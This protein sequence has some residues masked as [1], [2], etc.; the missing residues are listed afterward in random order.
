MRIAS[1]APSGTLILQELGAANNLVACTSLCPLPP[2]ERKRLS[3]GTFTTLDENKLAA[4]KP[5]VVIT[6]T[7]VQAKRSAQLQAHGY[8]V[9]HLDPRSLQDI[10]EH[11]VRLAELVGYKTAGQNVRDEM[12]EDINRLRE[13]KSIHRPRVY[14][15]EWADPPFVAGNWVPEMVEVAGGVAVLSEP[16]YPSRPITDEQL[17]QTDPDII[18]QHVCTPP[19]WWPAPEQEQLRQQQRQERLR[20]LKTRLGWE[21]LSAVRQGRVYALDDSLF[22]MPTQIVVKGIEAL[23][24]VFNK[25]SVDNFVAEPVKTAHGI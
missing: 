24:H 21:S 8:T 15:E 17:Q 25:I 2:L 1:L 5:D 11:Y 7:I 12:L 23:E 10:A 16:G 6:A 14:M 3:V 22:I 20:Q 19:L 9:M 18:I 13:K 4:S